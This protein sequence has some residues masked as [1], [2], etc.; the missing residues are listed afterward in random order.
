MNYTR[1]IE[2][3]ENIAN[4]DTMILAVIVK[5]ILSVFDHLEFKGEMPPIQ[6][7]SFLKDELP[8]SWGSSYDEET[9]KIFINIDAL[10][11]GNPFS[12]K[13]VLLSHYA[14]WAAVMHVLYETEPLRPSKEMRDIAD[15][16]AEELRGGICD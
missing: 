10:E 16:I 9:K 6:V 7:D 11:K 4:A 12:C 2:K 15:K 5:S 8:V 1:E 3:V 13:S 14:S